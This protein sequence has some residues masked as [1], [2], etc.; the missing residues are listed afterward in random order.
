MH[1]LAWLGVVA[2]CGAAAAS[3]LVRTPRLRAGAMLLAL[4]LA[5]VLVVGDVWDTERFRELRDSP[6]QVAALA[7]VA[8]VGIALVAGA[9]LRWAAALPLLAIGVMAFR[10]PVDVGGET[11]NL[12]IPLY[13]VVAGG[14]VAFAIRTQRPT[15]S[16][17]PAPARKEAPGSWRGRGTDFAT[18]PNP[19]T[20][21]IG[22]RAGF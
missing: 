18:Y 7:A 22:V 6:T 17:P 14:T 21:S 10:I 1:A 20:F 13:L 19:R 5:P 16:D 3:L 15:V 11:S 2:A 8:V 12:L 4:A 9:M